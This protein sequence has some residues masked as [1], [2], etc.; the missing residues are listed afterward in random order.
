MD[1]PFCGLAVNYITSM[2]GT[3]RGD[4]IRRHECRAC[5]NRW[6]S[7]DWVIQDDIETDVTWG[8][9][10]HQGC[11]ACLHYRD[12]YCSLGVPE[13]YEAGFVTKCVAACCAPLVL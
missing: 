4:V 3:S 12:G 10:A 8:V 1:C 11:A 5:G 2:R 6:R 7:S 9:K 13:A